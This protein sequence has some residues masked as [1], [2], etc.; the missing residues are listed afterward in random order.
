MPGELLA[1]GIGLEVG[2]ESVDFHDQDPGEGVAVGAGPGAVERSVIGAGRLC[3]GSGGGFNRKTGLGNDADRIVPADGI[4]DFGLRDLPMS[5]AAV[6][7]DNLDP[8]PGAGII[9][10]VVDETVTGEAGIPGHPFRDPDVLDDYGGLGSHLRVL[11]GNKSKSHGWD[12]KFQGHGIRE[13]RRDCWGL[14]P[15]IQSEMSDS[16]RQNERLFVNPLFRRVGWNND[17]GNAS[18]Q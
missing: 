14:L 7:V 8:S 2:V 18:T 4:G 6:L 9:G 11:A 12:Q 13:S 10:L 16:L 17:G 15:S 3:D 1:D 5:D